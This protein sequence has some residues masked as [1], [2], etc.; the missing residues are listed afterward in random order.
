MY[1]EKEKPES[2]TEQIKNYKEVLFIELV[3]I[4]FLSKYSFYYVNFRIDVFNYLSPLELLLDTVIDI[5]I[6]FVFQIV[7]YI[8]LFKLSIK[9][10]DT[11]FK[12][13]HDF[14]LEHNLFELKELTYLEKEKIKEIESYKVRRKRIKNIN[15]GI[16]FF[17]FLIGAFF[18]YKEKYIISILFFIIFISFLQFQV[19]KKANDYLH[20]DLNNEEYANK[21]VIIP[22]LFCSLLCLSLYSWGKGY[23]IKNTDYEIKSISFV[24][25][26]NIVSTTSNLKLIGETKNHLFLYDKIKNETLFFRIN[27][28]KDLKIVHKKKVYLEEVNPSDYCPKHLDL[29]Y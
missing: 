4:A 14:V 26:N 9:L 17:L 6:L 16:Y 13:F 29:L 21:T 28:I 15:Y 10:R 12:K 27:E 3:L 1:K 2:L 8:V 11:K 18:M 23:S 25:D 20:S 22:I 5:S 24:K 19:I 7:I